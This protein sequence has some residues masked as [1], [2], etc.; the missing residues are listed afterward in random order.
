MIIGSFGSVVRDFGNSLHDYWEVLLLVGAVLGASV[1]FTRRLLAKE[2]AQVGQIVEEKISPIRAEVTTN[3]GGSIKDVVK[4]L[5]EGQTS[6]TDKL[7]HLGSIATKNEGRLSAVTANLPAAY[8]EMDAVGNVTYVNDSYLKLYDITE[9]EALHSQNWRTH[10]SNDDLSLIDRS[11]AK[12]LE[13]QTDWFCSFS[14]IRDGVSIPV[15][16]RAKA[17]FT[18]GVFSGYSGAMVYNTSLIKD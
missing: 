15:T 13:T 17:L 18:N 1:R 5:E 12:A 16:A 4:R 9:Q 7:E 6:I 11:G 2:I 8:Y 14:V 3:G 10:I